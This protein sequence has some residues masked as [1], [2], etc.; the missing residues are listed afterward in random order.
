MKKYI[1]LILIAIMIACAMV[2]CSTTRPAGT[3]PTIDSSGGQQTTQTTPGSQD[4]NPR[5]DETDPTDD[6]TNPTKPQEDPE[7]PSDPIDP[8]DETEPPEPEQV[9]LSFTIE[10]HKFH[11]GD[12]LSTM[13]KHFQF[14]QSSLEDK[15]MSEDEE[16]I[17]LL[18][19][20]NEKCIKVKVA[21][22]TED[23]LPID[24]CII[25]ALEVTHQI[26]KEFQFTPGTAFITMETSI[27]DIGE[28]LD[29]VTPLTED[30]EHYT[31]Y[32]WVWTESLEQ[33]CI[34][35]AAQYNNKTKKIETIFMSYESWKWGN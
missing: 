8:P 18:L 15:I 3:N 24:Q 28:I 33:D 12:K 31:A 25:S 19:T 23:D 34:A 7:R 4:D 26:G 5:P 1:T 29:C 32:I 30:H 20:K 13:T 16:L 9:K 27:E 21:N 22:N 11:F 14:V 17:L 10:G 2:G 6:E 35:I